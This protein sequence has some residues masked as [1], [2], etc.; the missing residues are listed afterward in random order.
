MRSWRPRRPH[1]PRARGNPRRWT[2]D[3][4][5]YFPSW[6]RERG[7]EYLATGAVVL[8]A[9]SDRHVR[10]TVLGAEPHVVELRRR[11]TADALS[12][13]T[14]AHAR[15]DTAWPPE[16]EIVYIVD[17]D[18]T[19]KQQGVAVAL[20]WRQRTA[21]DGWTKPKPLKLQARLL[22]ALPDPADRAVWSLLLGARSAYE[23]PFA[24]ETWGNDVVRLRGDLE[25][26]VF[27]MMLATGRGFVRS[28][29]RELP[30]PLAW[31][32]GE[33]WEFWLTVSED[34]RDYVVSGS[35]RRGGE[36]R[37][38]A[39]PVVLTESGLVVFP[40][41]AARL[42]HADAFAWVAA[43]RNGGDLRVPRGEAP[44]LL[45]ALTRSARP[46]RIEL[47]PALSFRAATVPPRP[48]LTLS[49]PPGRFTD[50][51]V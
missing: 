15:A 51:L 40:A 41:E 42:D 26:I 33:P 21:K 9:V 27:P 18:A 45:G 34:E 19:M 8:D 29:P 49:R 14:H 20:S 28:G 47:P 43:L 7:E 46:P 31:D 11:P 48:R 35:L 17:C 1:R 2:Q 12:S 16:R 10:G 6:L 38:L 37:S 39:A 3:F 36:S 32:G 50:R 23:G 5:R 4:A 30:S 25:R 44:A 24:Y 13:V 22:A